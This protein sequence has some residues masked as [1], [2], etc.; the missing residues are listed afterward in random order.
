MKRTRAAPIW[1][2]A[3]AAIVVAGMLVGWSAQAGEDPPAVNPFGRQTEGRGEGVPGAIE[4]S[5]GSVRRGR[6]SLTR[7]KRL[8]VYDES[9]Q[10]QREVPLDLVRQIDCVVRRE[11]LEK[12][13]RFK[14]TTSDEKVYTGR[15]YPVREAAYKITLKDGR[16]VSGT[17]SRILY[18]AP[19]PESPRDR[20]NQSSEPERYLLQKRSKGQP[21][22][23]LKALVY[24]KQVRL[25]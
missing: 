13:W 20:V 21:G 14:E 19:E 6:I 23:D 25:E 15:T 9:A 3:K 12:E 8:Q 16:T 24:V 7:D 2:A 18:L 5:D 11:W 22:Q 10:R 17:M 4:L 1:K